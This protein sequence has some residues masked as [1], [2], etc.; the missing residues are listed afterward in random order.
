MQ[1]FICLGRTLSLLGVLATA[2]CAAG[3]DD[4]DAYEDELGATDAHDVL[5]HAV[6]CDPRRMGT[7]GPR[8]AT[9]EENII[10]TKTASLPVDVRAGYYAEPTGP[11]ATTEDGCA[12]YQW[13]QGSLGRGTIYD[14]NGRQLEPGVSCPADSGT[15]AVYGGILEAWARADFERGLG[16]PSSDRQGGGQSFRWQEEGATPMNGGLVRTVVMI[17]DSADGQGSWQ[18]HRFYQLGGGAFP[19]GL[20][21]HPQVC[22]YIPY[23]HCVNSQWA[24]NYAPVDPG[25]PEGEILWCGVENYESACS[26]SGPSP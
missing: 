9:P 26:G 23:S 12:T 5:E 10:W 24:W 6:T 11:I 22:K 2:A 7:C 21:T 1:L 15:Y 25:A 8:K 14:V 13:Y 19:G 3:P 16:Y 20:S 18:E 17:S 4:P